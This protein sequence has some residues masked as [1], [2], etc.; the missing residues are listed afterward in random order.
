MTDSSPRISED[1]LRNTRAWAAA[2]PDMSG[3][4]V[5]VGAI[6]ELIELR[7]DSAHNR[8]EYWKAEHIAANVEIER[9][10][11][12]LTLAGNRETAFRRANGLLKALMDAMEDCI[13]VKENQTFEQ[14]AEELI[15]TEVNHENLRAAQPP[16]EPA[17]K[18]PEPGSTCG[19][20]C[21]Y[22]GG[23]T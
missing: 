15:V 6:D 4:T 7:R 17:S 13:G 23:C 9:L 16:A 5:I 10:Q 20:D 12:E 2:R 14:R 11:H 21:G 19:P 18:E 8:A 22:C 1:R 3:S